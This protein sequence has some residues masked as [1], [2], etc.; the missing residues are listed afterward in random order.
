MYQASDR[1][2]VWRTTSVQ[3]N[4]FRAHYPS[5]TLRPLELWDSDSSRSSPM[6]HHIFKTLL[7]SL[8]VFFPFFHPHQAKSHLQVGVLLVLMVRLLRCLHEPLRK[9]IKPNFSFVANR[10][11]FSFHLPTCKKKKRKTGPTDFPKWFALLDFFF[12][13]CAFFSTFYFKKINK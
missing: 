9:E 1:P 13:F 11:F 8:F 7:S 5:L 6:T 2:S 12:F 3:L 4:T 10:F